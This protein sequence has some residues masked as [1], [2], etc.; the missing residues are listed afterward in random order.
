MTTINPSRDWSILLTLSSIIFVG[1]VAWNVWAFDTVASG[2]A[3]GSSE[4]ISQSVFSQSLLDTIETI[5]ANRA[6]EETKYGT[7]SYRFSDPSQ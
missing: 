7:G 3:F 2:K 5:F 1:I 6:A 4:P